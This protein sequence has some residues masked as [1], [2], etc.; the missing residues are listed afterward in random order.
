MRILTGFYGLI[1][2]WTTYVADETC[3]V[4][5][6]W[7]IYSNCMLIYY[8]ILYSGL[9]KP[10]NDETEWELEFWLQQKIQSDFSETKCNHLGIEIF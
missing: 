4:L 6:T 9:L 5:F 2:F 8:N 1:T 3:K 7:K 10:K